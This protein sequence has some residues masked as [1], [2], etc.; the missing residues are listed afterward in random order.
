MR[1]LDVGSAERSRT[2]PRLR[3]VTS[4]GPSVNAWPSYSSLP[5]S[6]K[7]A[8]A[9]WNWRSGAA[10]P[11]RLRMNANAS[12]TDEVSGPLRRNSHSSRYFG[13]SA[14]YNDSGAIDS[15]T[16]VQYGW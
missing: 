3:G 14:P 1:G 8:G 9:K 11:A 16:G 15:N 6:T 4:T 12:A 10:R 13:L 2:V 5:W 7:Y